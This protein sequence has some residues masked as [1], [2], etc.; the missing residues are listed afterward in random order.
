I[1]R[2]TAGTTLEHPV[3]EGSF[4]RKGWATAMFTIQRSVPALLLA[5]GLLATPACAAQRP[6]YSGG[7]RDYRD[8][9]RRAYDDGYRRGVDNGQRDAR[10]RRDFRVDRDR[11]YR[12]VDN[13]RGRDGYDYVRFFRDG[14]REGYTEG[15]NRVARYDRYDRRVY[16]N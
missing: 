11:V 9:E 8:F 5:A 6:Y 14:Y 1:R 2:S 13:R 16:P 4:H 7:Q 3:S 15:Y 10:E 12:D